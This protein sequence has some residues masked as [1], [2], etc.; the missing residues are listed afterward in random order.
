VFQVALCLVAIQSHAQVSFTTA[1]NLAL[2][3]SPRI[4]AAQNDLQKA[5]SGLAVVKDIYIPSVVTGGGIGE[6]YGIT[7]SLPTI[8]TINAQSLVYSA[9][10]SG[11]IRAAHLDLQAS[12]YALAEARAEMEEDAAITYV[13]LDN[14]QEVMGTLAEQYGYATKLDS[15]I[16]DRVNA[17]LDSELELL[18][19]RREAVQIKLQQLQ[20]QDDLEA[21]RAHLAQIT[22]LSEGDITTASDSVP[23]LPSQILTAVEQ[24]ARLEDDAGMH[25]AEANA[26]AKAQRARADG[27][28]TWRPTINFGAQYGRISPV[29]DV[30]SFYNLH[31]NYNTA[32]VGIAI[33]LPLLDK[34]RKAAAQESRLDARRAMLDLNNLRMDELEG[35]RRLQRSIPELA[36]KAELSDLDLEIARDELQSTTI[37]LHASTGGPPLTPKEELRAEMQERQRYLECLDAKLQLFKAQIS[38]LRQSGAL[39][40]WLQSLSGT[41]AKAR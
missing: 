12:T 41:P 1:I 33:Q 24:S 16:Q 36:A 17:N 30:S 37:Q 34:V 15:V 40:D 23:A 8:F 3:N 27:R 20:S 38:L 4:K 10:Q 11:Y 26:E 21:T 35:H 28:Y 31:G 39:E 22:G 6:T 18:K 2:R 32:N 7:L 25:A 13:A 19:V 5:Q 9:Q 29:N 14:S